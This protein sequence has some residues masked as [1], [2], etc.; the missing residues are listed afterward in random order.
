MTRLVRLPWGDWVD[1]RG[2]AAVTHGWEKPD[3]ETLDVF[4]LVILREGQTLHDTRHFLTPESTP[5]LEA[6][7]WAQDLRDKAASIING[8]AP[9]PYRSEP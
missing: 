7:A 5:S 6:Q 1:P 8:P 4:A 9:D 3:A 2:V